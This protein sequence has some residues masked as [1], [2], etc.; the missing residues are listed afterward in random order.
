[1]SNETSIC[2]FGSGAYVLTVHSER[3][4]QAWPSAFGNVPFPLEGV[5]HLLLVFSCK[6]RVRIVV[7]L[8]DAG[9]RLE[10]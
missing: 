10:S 6:L 8:T 3:A 7:F 1:M 5:L 9:G 2:N 4:P